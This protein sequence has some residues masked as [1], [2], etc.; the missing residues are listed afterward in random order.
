MR[1]A[2]I[3]AGIGGLTAAAFLSRDGHDVVVYESVKELTEVG[4]GIIVSSNATRVIEALGHGEELAAIGTSP[5][6]MS[7]R[8]WQ[9]D[10]EIAQS[11][12]GP[13]ATDRWGSPFYNVYRPDMAE[14]LYKACPDVTFKFGERITGLTQ[15]SDTVTLELSS[16]KSV[17]ADI[18]IGA[19]GIHS[20]VRTQLWGAQP[21]R[22]SGIV[23]Y[24]IILDAT[25]VPGMAIESTVRLG[26]GGHIVSYPIGRNSHLF[27]IV[28]ITDDPSWEIES[29]NEPADLKTL[30]ERFA[31]W[32]PEVRGLLNKA[33]DPIYR[34][35]LHDRQ[36]LEKWGSGLVT[37]LGDACH[38]MLPFMA[39][40]ASQAI[41]DASVLSRCLRNEQDPRSALATYETLR[42]ERATSIQAVSLAN[43]TA[44][45]LPDGKDQQDRDEF[46]SLVAASEGG[47]AAN[48]DWIYA[49]TDAS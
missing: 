29:W 10:S 46:F 30:R 27:N 17:E 9:D 42:H 22:F 41:E 47:L 12:L 20:T 45:H 40:G 31:D 26:P 2:V 15:N 4:A 37:L 6:R 49:N 18:V 7:F 19:D 33:T 28:A 36:P 11:T 44:F 24:R 5:Q 34:W 25:E 39:Q 13:K 48:F 8:R 32:S 1:V 14:M 3:G 16:G 43:A 38:P 21:S 23:A 35:A